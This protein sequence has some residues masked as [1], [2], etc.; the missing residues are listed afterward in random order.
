[1]STDEHICAKIKIWGSLFLIKPD[2]YL[3][4][5]IGLGVALEAGRLER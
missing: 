5:T 2:N 3:Y 1:M 4:G